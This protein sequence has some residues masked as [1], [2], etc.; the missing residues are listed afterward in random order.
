MEETLTITSDEA[1]ALLKCP[2]VEI[3]GFV[4]TARATIG[5]DAHVLVVER[6]SDRKLFFAPYQMLN[7][8]EYFEGKY[9][10]VFTSQ[11][12]LPH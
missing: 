7:D 10:A 6:A 12:L 5:S 2:R 3:R 9:P 4:H 1:N 8:Y 11:N